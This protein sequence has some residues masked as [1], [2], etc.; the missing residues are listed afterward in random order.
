MLGGSQSLART[1]LPFDVSKVAAQGFDCIA[2][3]V[4]FALCANPEFAQDRERR[5]PAVQC[6]LQ[7]KSLNDSRQGQPLLVAEQS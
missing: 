2:F 3:L 4:D 7:E 1:S 5:T 6:M